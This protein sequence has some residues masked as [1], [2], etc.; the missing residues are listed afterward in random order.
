MGR[1]TRRGSARDFSFGSDGGW[2]RDMIGDGEFFSGLDAPGG[3]FF[4]TNM[5]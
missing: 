1:A 4:S 2:W 5:D 3:R